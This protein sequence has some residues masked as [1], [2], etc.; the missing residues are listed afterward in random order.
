MYLIEDPAT[1]ARCSYYVA[2]LLAA[3]ID[4]WVKVRSIRATTAPR[5]KQPKR[6][7]TRPRR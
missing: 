3:L 7:A 4:L 6:A 1:A 5:R 2:R